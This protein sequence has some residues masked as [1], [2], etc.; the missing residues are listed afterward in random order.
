[1][2]TPKVGEAFNPCEVPHVFYGAH[3]PNWLMQRKEINLLAKVLY[4]RFC[5]YA[6]TNSRGI[7]PKVETLAVEL[8]CSEKGVRNAI[9]E[10]EE[11]G[12]LRVVDRRGERMSSQYSLV[13]HEWQDAAL[14]DPKLSRGLTAEDEDDEESPEEE[15]PVS[16]SR[17]QVVSSQRPAKISQRPANS[18]GLKE[19]KKETKEEAN[20]ES[21][22]ASRHADRHDSTT[23]EETPDPSRPEQRTEDAATAEPTSTE[24]YVAAAIAKSKDLL[25]RPME[26]IAA[27]KQKFQEAHAKKLAKK[28]MTDERRKQR[29]KQE[30]EM[31]MEPAEVPP[32]NPRGRLQYVW[33]EE[34]KACFSQYPVAR[35]WSGK[36]WKVA[37]KLLESYDLDHV[38]VAIVYVI[39]NW[40]ALRRRFFKDKD[41]GPTP[42]LGFLQY[43]NSSLLPE[44]VVWAEQ[45]KIVEEYEAYGPANAPRPAELRDRYF[46]AVRQLKGLGLDT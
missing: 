39:R 23:E 3:F 24:D 2:R 30:R 33:R 16:S 4:A 42:T 18:A 21:A 17:R 19:I 9:Q 13:W 37:E 20:E 26:T 8:G 27:A 31:G 5:Q 34:M 45:G 11:A 43:F 12:L 40:E 10:L 22:D 14:A 38:E 1:M 35:Q 15:R 28:A 41:A 46:E 44:S 25:V 32:E 6:G 36:D 29:E 7:F